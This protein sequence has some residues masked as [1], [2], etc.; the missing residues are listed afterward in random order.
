MHK[1][2]NFASTASL[3]QPALLSGS[4]GTSSLTA[5]ELAV[6]HKSQTAASIPADYTWVLCTSSP[7]LQLHI[8]ICITMADVM[9]VQHIV[10]KVV[11][12][13]LCIGHKK[14]LRRKDCCMPC[15]FPYAGGCNRQ[16]GSARY[17]SAECA[18]VGWL[19]NSNVLRIKALQPGGGHV[20]CHPLFVTSYIPGTCCF[21]VQCMRLLQPCSIAVP[22]AIAC[23]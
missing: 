1:S 4:T 14:I 15:V 7:F 22:A 23:L 8:A 20:F 10:H 16:A 21:D 11:C 12:L 18:D 6:S 2:A 19:T 9:S 13:T 17:S 5:D 3:Q